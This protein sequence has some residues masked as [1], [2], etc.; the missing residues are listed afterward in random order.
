[1][2]KC[3]LRLG[4]A[5]AYVVCTTYYTN[6]FAQQPNSFEIDC[7][8]DKLFCLNK[9]NRRILFINPEHFKENYDGR[10]TCQT[11]IMFDSERSQTRFECRCANGN[12][13]RESCAQVGG[14]YQVQTD[15]GTTTEYYRCIDGDCKNKG[16]DI[17]H[18]LEQ[19]GKTNLLMR[20]L[21][22]PPSELVIRTKEIGNHNITIS[23]RKPPYAYLFQ[24]GFTCR[25]VH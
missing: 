17:Y 1:M 20:V 18:R 24:Y 7:P 25:V 13:S 16:W 2:R 15:S 12:T 11:D 19:N 9:S 14:S 5:L 8:R 22:N 3:L 6:A 23:C 4:Y 10:A 21:I